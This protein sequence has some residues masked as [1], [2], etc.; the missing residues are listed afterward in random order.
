MPKEY[1]DCVSNYMKK[2]VSEKAAKARCAAAFY[3]KHGITVNEWVQK[4]GETDSFEYDEEMVKVLLE[5]MGDDK[6]LEPR[7]CNQHKQLFSNVKTM[8]AS[9]ISDGLIEIIAARDGSLAYTPEGVALTYT[10]SSLKNAQKTWQGTPV[11][12]NHNKSNHGT[13]KCSWFDDNEQALHQILQLDSYLQGWVMRNLDAEGIGV[14]I[15]STLNEFDDDLNILDAI[16]RGVT[17]VLPPHSPACSKEDGC[18]ILATEVLPTSQTNKIEDE[19]LDESVQINSE[20]DNMVNEENKNVSI[21]AEFE[22]VK[23]EKVKLEAEI[24]SM[25]AELVELKSFKTKTIEAERVVLLSTIK[26]FGLDPVVYE[27]NDNEA[28]KLIVS[29]AESVRKSMEDDPIVDSGATISSTK[30]TEPQKS[31]EEREADEV[32]SYVYGNKK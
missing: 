16:G 13:V 29:T 32:W 6:P 25:K 21:T 22:A 19:S 28:L 2:G 11:S 23:A 3:K 27:K 18:M 26:N 7:K 17:I 4:N 5:S 14:S 20:D 1:T 15:E 10:G 8:D 9:Q 24:E 12:I 30:K 31:D